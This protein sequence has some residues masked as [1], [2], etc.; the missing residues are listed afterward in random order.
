MGKSWGLVPA[1]ALFLNVVKS[2]SHSDQDKV[3]E[4]D[5]LVSTPGLAV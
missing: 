5:Q 3:L 2:L 4:L 1:L